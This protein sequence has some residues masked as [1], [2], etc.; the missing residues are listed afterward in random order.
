MAIIVKQTHNG[1]GIHIFIIYFCHVITWNLFHYSHLRRYYDNTLTILQR[2]TFIKHC[3]PLQIFIVF[4]FI[5]W[6]IYSFISMHIKKIWYERK[7]KLFQLIYNV[8]SIEIQCQRNLT[9]WLLGCINIHANKPTYM[10]HTCLK[11]K[12]YSKEYFY[13]CWSCF[14]IK[15]IYFSPQI[16]LY[17]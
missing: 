5:L 6:K 3:H 16:L 2:S 7:F 13:R 4:Y 12:K 8:Y 11:G 17:T 14:I 15:E 9:N 10:F 1:C